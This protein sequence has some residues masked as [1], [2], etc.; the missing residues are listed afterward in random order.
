MGF[1]SP[2]VAGETETVEL[3]GKDLNLWRAPHG[4]WQVVGSVRA[5]GAEDRLL[6]GQP[7]E[8]IMLNG[9]QGRTSNILSQLEH[10]D[11]QAH[12]E[13]MV[14]KGS[15]SGVYFQARY[16]IQFRADLAELAER[17]RRPSAQ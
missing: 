1:T 4:D 5:G 17:L 6:V 11:V 9:P 15:N 2:C 10:G 14:P 12:V 16:E 8:G 13:F 7:G 3:V